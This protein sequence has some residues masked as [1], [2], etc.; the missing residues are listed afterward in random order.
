[1]ISDEIY[2][3]LI[4]DGAP[5]H[6]SIASLNPEIFERTIV[7]NGFSKSYSMTGWRVGYTASNKE[8]AKV[9]GSLQSH[10][11]SNANSIAQKAATE[12]LCGDQSQVETMR[13]EFQKRRDYI[14]ERVCG[15]KHL[16]AVKP[17]GAFYI[18]VNVT[19]LC[20]K[21]VNGKFMKNA[22][23]IAE[24]LL[25][26]ANVAVVPCADFGFENHILLSYPV[27]IETIKAGMDKIETFI[28]AHY[29]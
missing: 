14:Y 3:K 8:I 2:E 26:E 24:M 21:T 1:V 17:Q 5:K 15:I 4:Y 13:Q 29:N 7:V 10:G 12:A 11:T 20:G 22:A 27:S 9:M 19:E 25:D 28:N 23:D 16:S 6:V 18:F